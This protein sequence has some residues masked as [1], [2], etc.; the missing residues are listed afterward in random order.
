MSAP[1]IPVIPMPDAFSA[2]VWG[3]NANSTHVLWDKAMSHLTLDEATAL[4]L[5]GGRELL[6]AVADEVAL[7]VMLRASTQFTY[8]AQKLIRSEIAKRFPAPTKRIRNVV[9]DSMERSVWFSGGHW[10]GTQPAPEL[11][12][13]YSNA[14]SACANTFGWGEADALFP[15]V[16][17]LKDTPTVEVDASDPRPAVDE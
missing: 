12:R 3:S 10:Y 5:K 6:R 4:Q 13:K 9:T 14:A 15:A 2:A 11:V 16:L 8:E 17:A 1:K 7:N